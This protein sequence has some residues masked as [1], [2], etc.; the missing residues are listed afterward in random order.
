[1][2]PAPTT[3]ALGWRDGAIRDPTGSRARERAALYSLVIPGSGQLVQ[4]RSRWPL[5]VAA[6]VAAWILHLDRREDGKRLRDAYRELAWSEARGGVGPSVVDDF[7]Y[8]ERLSTWT[9][10]GAWDGDPAAP[11]LQPETDP[12]TFNG[13]VWRRARRLFFGPEPEGVGPGDPAWERALTFYAEEAYGPALVWDWAEAG[14]GSRDRFVGL[15]RR[16][17]DHF[18]E[19]TLLL[20]AIVANH[21]LSATDA[22]VTARRGR[23]GTSPRIDAGVGLPFGPGAHR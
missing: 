4:G 15:L 14:D 21:L 6:E 10:S 9:S 7:E 3:A 22:F 16:S 23:P 17:D 1:M 11:G 18:G 20:G 5:Y 2:T 8:Y 19:A 12:A 13:S